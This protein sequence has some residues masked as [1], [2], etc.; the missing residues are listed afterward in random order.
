ME[1]LLLCQ[2]AFQL[3]RV[4]FLSPFFSIFLFARLLCFLSC[5]AALAALAALGALIALMVL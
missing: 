2:F 1:L 4:L 3:P 5:L